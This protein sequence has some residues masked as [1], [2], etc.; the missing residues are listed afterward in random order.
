MEGPFPRFSLVINSANHI[1]SI[2]PTV[3]ERIIFRAMIVFQLNTN[4]FI[5]PKAA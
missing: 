2:D 4:G 5:T 1:E 3:N